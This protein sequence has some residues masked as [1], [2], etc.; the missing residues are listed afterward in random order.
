MTSCSD[1]DFLADCGIIPDLAWLLESNCFT[2]E[3]QKYVEDL[4][5]INML[6]G[7]GGEIVI[8]KG[9]PSL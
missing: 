3:Q 4:L 7:G 5:R 6:L 8:M 9:E 1:P 2:P